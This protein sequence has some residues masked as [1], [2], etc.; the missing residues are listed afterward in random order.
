MY[1]LYTLNG[2][3]LII[4]Y[5]APTKAMLRPMMKSPTIAWRL[6]DKNG[7]CDSHNWAKFGPHKLPNTVIPIWNKIE[8]PKL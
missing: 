4:G 7:W 1:A 8:I 2:F 6:R 5:V 3:G